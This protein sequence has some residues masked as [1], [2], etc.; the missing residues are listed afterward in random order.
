MVFLIESFWQVLACII[1]FSQQQQLFMLT[2]L[3][4][5]EETI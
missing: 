3:M 5:I 1:Y 2:R 4:N